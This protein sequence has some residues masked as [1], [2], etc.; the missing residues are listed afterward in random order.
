MTNESSKLRGPDVTGLHDRVRELDERWAREEERHKYRDPYFGDSRDTIEANPNCAELP[1]RAR[2]AWGVVS[3]ALAYAFALGGYFFVR[4]QGE[5]AQMAGAI[6][7]VVGLTAVTL[8]FGYH[9]VQAYLRYVCYRAALT[10]YQSARAELMRE[11]EG[12]NGDM[13]LKPIA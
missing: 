13:I 3:L 8:L 9:I 1:S 12:A 6:L 4:S 10:S 5:L 11:I 7:L 2:I